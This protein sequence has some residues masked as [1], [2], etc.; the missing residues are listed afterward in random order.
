MTSRQLDLIRWKWQ[1]AVLS[2]LSAEGLSLAS[3]WQL[4]KACLA[5]VVA[6]NKCIAIVR[7]LKAEQTGDID[8]E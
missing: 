2:K 5:R 8:Y 4:I 7:Q 6:P 3:D 1:Q